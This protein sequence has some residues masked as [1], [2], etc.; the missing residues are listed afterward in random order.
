[1]TRQDKTRILSLKRS[2]TIGCKVKEIR[3]KVIVIY[4]FLRTN[5]FPIEF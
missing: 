5:L 1:M 3:N 4:V 2:T